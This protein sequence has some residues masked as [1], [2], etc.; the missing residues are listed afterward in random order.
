MRLKKHELFLRKCNRLK[1]FFLIDEFGQEVTPNWG[2]ALAGDFFRSFL[3]KRGAY[4]VITTHYA[5]SK[6]LGQ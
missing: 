2:G 3:T 4:G 6:T 5:N 1:P